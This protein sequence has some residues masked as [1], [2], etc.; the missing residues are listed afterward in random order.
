VAARYAARNV[1]HPDKLGEYRVIATLGRGGMADVYLAVRGGLVGFSKLVVVKRLRDDLATAPEA[2][3]Y[4]ALLL[5]EARLAALLRHP[6]IVQTF[7]VNEHAGEPFL[8]MEYLDGQPL[9]NVVVAAQK[10][11]KPMPLAMALRVV[12][13][14]LGALSYA[15]ELRGYDG[16]PLDVVHRD[17]SPQNVFVT[18]DG[19]VKLVDFG[20]AK[21]AAANEQT[22]AGVIKGK[23]T[24]M[25]PEQARGDSIDGR[26]DVFATGIIMFEL[27]ANQRLL[28][29]E[30]PAA[31]MQKL[32]FDELPTIASVRG[33][34]D[35]EIS[36]ICARALERD[37]AKRYPSAAEMRREI[38]RV[39]ARMEP[40]SRDDIAAFVR[41]LFATERE[42]VAARIRH[43]M[44]APETERE[45]LTIAEAP[46]SLSLRSGWGSRA[47]NTP[48]EPP[49]VPQKKK[50][51]GLFVALGLGAMAIAGL[52]I[53]ARFAL[54]SD[55]TATSSSAAASS[56][57]TSAPL[58]PPDLGLCGSN[59]IGAELAPALVEALLKKKG[60]AQVTRTPGKDQRLVLAADIGGKH[61]SVEIAARGTATAFE[62]LA[63]GACDIGMAS[64]PINDAELAKVSAAGRG[65]LRTP[66]TEHVIA[67]DGIAVIVNPNNSLRALDRASLHDIFVGKITDWSA[68]GGTPGAITV[69]ARDKQSGTYDTFKHLVMGSDDVVATAARKAESDALSDA[70]ASNPS[71]I[72]FIGLAY[73]RSAKALA[74]GDK[75]GAPM[76]PTS[77]TVTT[78]E[79][80]LSRRLFFYT[81]STPRTPLVA[82][83]VSFALSAEGQNVVRATSFVDLSVGMHDGDP[84]G[85][86]CPPRY[87]A[88]TASAK[89][90]SLD[91]RFRAGG[92]E[93]DSRATRDLDRTVQFMRAHEGGRLA[94]LGFSDSTGDTNANVVL[95]RERAQ[96]VARELGTRGIRAAVVDGFGPLLPVTSNET[97]ADR[98]RNRRVEVW[99]RQ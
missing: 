47:M 80:M 70:V 27:V 48:P 69:F 65:D 79:Y 36:R 71:A 19:E 77:F 24:Y 78:E 28:R 25:A 44:T 46:S 51:T 90:L 55:H 39:L 61:T 23:V 88:A 59:T 16:R 72:G 4:R 60:A 12:A 98:E 50:T 18:Y 35:P 74:V 3:R 91:F 97:E 56:S 13:D 83:L 10:N 1:L 96:A 52:A 62:G 76:L 26:A 15:H 54:R 53:A 81:P 38:E 33:D 32:L 21:S 85:A 17:V 20:V 43:A 11:Q 40:V 2:P 30:T 6:N 73:I 34:L 68:V 42:E 84:C 31:S 92:S 63:S 82:E 5:D 29:M 89:R 95:S 9:N 7:E 49:P 93:L 58:P 57:I 67:L 8:A 87:A 64:R 22:T 41:E 37:V 66:A 94:L 99:L 45:L 75:G 14:V 86:R